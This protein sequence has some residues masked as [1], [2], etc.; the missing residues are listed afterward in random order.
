M[1]VFLKLHGAS[2]INM[3]SE[4]RNCKC[5]TIHFWAVD[6]TVLFKSS[7]GKVQSGEKLAAGWT[8]G[9][10]FQTEAELPFLPRP[11]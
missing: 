10:P 6:K 4:L 9:V 8:A 5:K 11:I 1:R 2:V 3:I 7:A